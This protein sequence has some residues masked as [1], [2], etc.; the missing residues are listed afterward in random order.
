MIWGPHA[1]DEPLSDNTKKPT[2]IRIRSA[3]K[4]LP[5]LAAG[6]LAACGPPPGPSVPYQPGKNLSAARTAVQS[7]V[8]AATKTGNG[9]I[10]GSYAASAVLGGVVVGPIIVATKH[11]KIRTNAEARGADKC[12]AKQGFVRRDLTVDEMRALNSHDQYVREALLDHLIGG[13]TLDTFYKS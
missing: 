12:L 2:A 5:F 13:G 9:T 7:C 8:P 4:F 6:V 3:A 1:G 11:N 10:I